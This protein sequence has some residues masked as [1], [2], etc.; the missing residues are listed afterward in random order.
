MKCIKF[1]TA[2]PVVSLGLLLTGGCASSQVQYLKTAEV[3]VAPGKFYVG[4]V[5]GMNNGWFFFDCSS[6]PLIS[7]NS[8][9]PNTNDYEFWDS[10]VSTRLNREM[11]TRYMDKRLSKEQPQLENI[12]HQSRSHGWYTLWI[13]WN[14]SI[15]SK[16]D[17]YIMRQAP[18]TTENSTQE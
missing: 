18:E 3:E 5:R 11:M 9:R 12:E 6:L 17:V 2:L 14:F 15:D 16:A 8:Y 1:W 13:L 4:E 10:A 7:G